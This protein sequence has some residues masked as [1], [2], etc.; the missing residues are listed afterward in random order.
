[1]RVLCEGGD[2]AT[3]SGGPDVAAKDGPAV[4]ANPQRQ[5]HAGCGKPRYEDAADARQ[6]DADV[7][8]APTRRSDHCRARFLFEERSHVPTGPRD[9]FW[10]G[11][12]MKTMMT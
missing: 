3:S 11:E 2:L 4:D 1:M 7:R 5:K 6:T 9:T 10:I 8:S 12:T